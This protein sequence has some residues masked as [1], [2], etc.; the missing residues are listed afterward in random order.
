MTMPEPAAEQDQAVTAEPE[1]F[2]DQLLDALRNNAEVEYAVHDAVERS[3][4]RHPFRQPP[5]VEAGRYAR[6]TR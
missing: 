3:A 1:T 6:T 5:A 2:A 4:L